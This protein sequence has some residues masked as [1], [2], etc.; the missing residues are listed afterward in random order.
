[1][2]QGESRPDVPS[3]PPAL[4]DQPRDN[5]A[6]SRGVAGLSPAEIEHIIAQRHRDQMRRRWIWVSA[7]VGLLV[8]A[9]FIA[10]PA[11]L[12]PVRALRL[13]LSGI[14]AQALVT[15]ADLA[16]MVCDS[17]GCLDKPY[18]IVNLNGG[19]VPPP[20][21]AS[22]MGSPLPEGSSYM[23]GVVERHVAPDADASKVGDAF[24]VWFVPTQGFPQDLTAE[25]PQDLA[26]S[27]LVSWWW[28]VIPLLVIALYPRIDVILLGR[29]TTG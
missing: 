4:D 23:L 27:G 10:L 11:M 25:R 7:I 12:H 26:L 6:L 17:S 22:D 3:D 5:V 20:I 13:Q 15:H 16:P 28:L 21:L 19:S 24:P 9:A 14:Q 18:A 1:M 8:L 2:N 29:R